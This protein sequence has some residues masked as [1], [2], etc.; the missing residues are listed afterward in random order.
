MLLNDRIQIPFTNNGKTTVKAGSLYFAGDRITDRLGVLGVAVTDVEP[1]ASGLLETS[2]IFSFEAETAVK[3]AK[4]YQQI[5][6][7]YDKS[8]NKVYLTLN[9]QDTFS[10]A[11]ISLT[12]R[13]TVGGPLILALGYNNPVY[14]APAS[15]STSSPSGGGAGAMSDSSTVVDPSSSSEPGAM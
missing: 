12:D 15:P 11:G 9:L 10:Y 4:L 13:P 6:A 5:Y 8:S 7:Y 2:G 3:S 14:T 1:G